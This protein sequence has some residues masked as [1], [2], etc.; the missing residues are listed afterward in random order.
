MQGG[1][2]GWVAIPL[3]I[4]A[5]ARAASAGIVLLVA[6]VAGGAISEG[7]REGGSAS[8]YLGLMTQ[9]DGQW[10]W[11][12]ARHGYPSE[13]P[14]DADGEVQESPWN[15]YPLYP[16]LVRALMAL[17]HLGFP[18]VATT[19]SLLCGA[20]AMVVLFGLLEP[21][22]RFNAIALVTLLST[23]PASPVLQSAYTEGLGLLL[24]V[25]AVT[26]T[27]RRRYGWLALAL[28][29]LSLTRAVAAP[30]MVVLAV[31]VVLRW[32]RRRADPIERREI[33]PG[34]LALAAALIG[35]FTWPLISAVALGDPL[36]YLRAASPWDALSA[37]QGPLPSWLGH[38]IA[39]PIS[40][41]SFF[42][43]VATGLLTWGVVRAGRA[44]P[45]ELRV[46]AV[47]YGVYVFGAT[48]LA[49]G[50]VRYS[51]LTILP[52]LPGPIHDD[53]RVSR[54]PRYAVLLFGVVTGLVL[55]AWWVSKVFLP[56]P[57]N[58]GSP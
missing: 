7:H 55:Q 37:S 4:Y 35:P 48:L 3:G 6:H 14:A 54:W 5:L 10:Y 31:H 30:L 43:V 45:L 49:V 11:T 41:T 32:R 23:R 25:L 27:M 36:A 38:A 26:L 12:I 47:S 57:G 17:T 20:L 46:W 53:V 15:F 18:L 52:W 42:I 21:A 13:L 44:L 22:S 16:M 51:L 56:L 2:F 50:F 40:R 33:L 28:V 19:L 9:W 39:H 24:I 8:G 34:T 58:L 1:R 29:A